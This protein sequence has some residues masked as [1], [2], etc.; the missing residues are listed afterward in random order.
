VLAGASSS[1][2]WW[3][4]FTLVSVC[5]QDHSVFV[6]SMPD[7]SM[8]DLLQAAIISAYVDATRPALGLLVI[9][10]ALGAVCVPLLLA[11]FYFSTA[12]SRRTPLFVIV[13]FEVAFGI[14]LSTW[15]VIEEVS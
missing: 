5:S 8:P 6:P 14:A 13:V 3:K 11:L 7:S 12:R 9:Y 15:I 2:E 1:S 4:T 10:S